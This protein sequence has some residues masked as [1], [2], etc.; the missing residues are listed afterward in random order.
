[1]EVTETGVMAEVDSAQR[2]LQALRNL[3]IGVAIDDFGTGYASLTYLRRLPATIVKVDRTFVDGLGHD[4]DDTAIVAAVAGLAT[5][6]GLSAIAEG[7]ETPQQLH[8]LIDAGYRYA[9]GH[10]FSRPVP[11]TELAALFDTN[12]LEPHLAHPSP[13]F[14]KQ[15]SPVLRG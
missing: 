12:L 2:A 5:A 3:G 4:S 15:L 11:A 8:A 6:L 10:L 13:P 14:N 7:V 1:M 9:Q